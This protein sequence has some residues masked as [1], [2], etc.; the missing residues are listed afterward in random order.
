MDEEHGHRNLFIGAGIVF[1]VL[2]VV[3]LIVHSENK[4]DERSAQKAGQLQAALQAHGMRAPS[5]QRII[6]LF[7]D[8]GG[9]TC[10]DPAGA[11]RRGIFYG[12]LVN[13]AGGPG[14]RPVLAENTVV[15]GQL[16]VMSIYC[17]DQLAEFQRV[18]DDLNLV[19]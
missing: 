7:G 19:S 6:G 10:D 14:S 5:T 2:L 8:D 18:V 9:P 11:L 12:Q 3:A 1:V 15:Q 16:V 4:E 13:G 17:P